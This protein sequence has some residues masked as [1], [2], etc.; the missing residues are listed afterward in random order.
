MGNKNMNHS[1]NRN[2]MYVS[3]QIEVSPRQK[4][5]NLLKYITNVHWRFN[6]DIIP[7]YIM[8][9]KICGL[10]LSLRYHKINRAYI[11][12]RISALRSKFMCRIL[13]LHL[14]DGD[15]RND[16]ILTELNKVCCINKL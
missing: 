14:D 12:G 6:N 11:H 15:N 13:V 7:D 10:Y 16:D 2:A 8:S 5:N 9:N 1:N 4:G 3:T